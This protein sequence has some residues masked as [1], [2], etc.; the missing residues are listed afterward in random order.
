[1]EF[2]RFFFFQ[3]SEMLKA[4]NAILWLGKFLSLF[5][6]HENA[7][8]T[9][10]VL[11]SASLRLLCLKR[12]D[13]KPRTWPRPPTHPPILIL[14]FK[15]YNVH[16]R[17]HN[18]QWP[19][20]WPLPLLSMKWSPSR[21]QRLNEVI[22]SESWIAQPPSVLLPMQKVSQHF[23]PMKWQLCRPTSRYIWRD[24]KCSNPN[25]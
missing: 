22:R 1:M 12:E 24:L 6:T 13:W 21:P 16:C 11:Y 14:Y 7:W 8:C 25:P 4:L 19:T 9:A 10:S 20:Q 2:L 17:L 23:K 15:V 3:I 5:S 18:V